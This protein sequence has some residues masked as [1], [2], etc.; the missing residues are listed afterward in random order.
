MS[1]PP[2][3]NVCN[4]EEDFQINMGNLMKLMVYLDRYKCKECEKNGNQINN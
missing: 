1:I 4:K 3:C 2:I